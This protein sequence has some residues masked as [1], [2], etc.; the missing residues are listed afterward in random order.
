MKVQPNHRTAPVPAPDAVDSGATQQRA[1]AR[2]WPTLSTE[3]TLSSFALSMDV[4]HGVPISF[5]VTLV[6]RRA[7]SEFL[8]P[9]Y[10]YIY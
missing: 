3:S 8:L 4:I 1:T 2:A 10:I 9:I 7:S 6:Y 5:L